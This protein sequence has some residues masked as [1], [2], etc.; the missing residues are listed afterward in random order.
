LPYGSLPFVLLSKG[1]ANLS[2][3]ILSSA[4]SFGS[5]GSL[6][7]GPGVGSGGQAGGIRF[8]SFASG[9][10]GG[11]FGGPGQDG[12]GTLGPQPPYTILTGGTGGKTYGDLNQQLQGGSM[13]GSTNGGYRG[14][15]GGAIEVGATGRLNISSIIDVSGSSGYYSTYTGPGT[16]GGGS[17]GGILLHGFS[18]SVSGTLNALGGSGSSS[19]SGIGGMYSWTAAPSGDGGGGRIAIDYNTAGSFSMTGNIL[20]GNGVYTVSAI[21]EPSPFI[22][23]AALSVVGLAARFRKSGST[24]V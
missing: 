6:G 16:G 24:P 5:A 7:S 2:G 15:G 23:A 20:I 18:V 9:S 21:P 19:G 3:K 10:G 12:A 11:G 8:F 22:L 13:G 1:D 17:G 4:N 14:L